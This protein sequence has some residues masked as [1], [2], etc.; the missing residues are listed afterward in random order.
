MI[1]T[2]S[3]TNICY[4]IGYNSNPHPTAPNMPYPG[5]SREQILKMSEKKSLEKTKVKWIF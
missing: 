5:L 2:I 3:H 1:A 4:L